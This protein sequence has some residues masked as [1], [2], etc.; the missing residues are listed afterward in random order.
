MPARNKTVT[1]VF[2]FIL[3]AASCAAV[4]VFS[5]RALV[6]GP[7]SLPVGLTNNSAAG[8]PLAGAAA[9]EAATP[10]SACR[11]RRLVNEFIGNRSGIHSIRAFPL[12]TDAGGQLHET[13]AGRAGNLSELRVYL[14]ACR[15][16]LGARIDA[17]K[18]G[19]V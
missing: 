2:D 7:A 15:V 3:R 10:D 8:A 1:G 14:L 19:V 18:L 11:A 5:G 17:R 13:G 9:N 6:P 16:K 4:K 12:E